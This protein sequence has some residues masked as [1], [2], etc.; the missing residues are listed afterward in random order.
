MSKIFV[1]LAC[2][3]CPHYERMGSNILW[4]SKVSSKYLPEY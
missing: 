1:V 4:G 3:N 2:H